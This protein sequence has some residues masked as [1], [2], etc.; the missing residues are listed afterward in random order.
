MTQ[1]R[2][3]PKFQFQLG[4]GGLTALAVS[5]VCVLLWIF[6]LGFWL[7]QKLVGPAMQQAPE[8]VVASRGDLEPRQV[9][10]PRPEIVPAVPEEAP[11]APAVPPAVE[12][13]PVT[14]GKIHEERI[15]ETAPAEPVA[16]KSGGPAPG[17]VA[18]EPV[19]KPASPEAP[20]A[21]TPEA[22]E[23]TTSFVLQIASYRERERAEGEV[24]RWGEK[25]YKV[26]MRRADLGPTKGI[27][28]R[29]YVGKFRTVEEATA[30]AKKLAE[31]EG[32]KSYVVPLQD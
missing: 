10:I 16:E 31:Q 7:G 4:W 5:A 6:V 11:E 18:E 29:V 8:T 21:K 17:P 13:G 22:G 28:Y 23:K 12:G 27:W 32:L 30:F 14:S 24:K 1:T 26:Q 20:A 2:K 25:G 9:E 15:D 19:Q 3:R